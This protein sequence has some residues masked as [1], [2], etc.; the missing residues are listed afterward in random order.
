MKS[1]PRQSTRQSRVALRAASQIGLTAE[2]QHKG[3]KQKKPCHCHFLIKIVIYCFRELLHSSSASRSSLNSMTR[4][5]SERCA[6]M[7][8]D[9]LIWRGR[10]VECTASA[11]WT[12]RLLSYHDWCWCWCVS[13]V[14]LVVSTSSPSSASSSSH[15][16]SSPASPFV[17]HEIGRASCRE[18]V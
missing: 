2:V 11:N 3:P 8:H 5:I 10:P 15:S 7:I 18:R 1:D 13:G 6:F 14:S 12:L 17:V 9:A 4:S 16:Q